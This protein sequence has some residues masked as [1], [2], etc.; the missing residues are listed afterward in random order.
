VSRVWDALRKSD[1]PPGPVE[2]R[3]PI[4]IGGFDLEQIPV[5]KIQIRSGHCLFAHTDPR[6]PAADRLRFLRMRLN[7]VWNPENL[8][9]ILITSPLPHDGKST[10]TINLAVTL[11]EQGKRPVLVIEGDLQRP[12]LSRELGLDDLA[13]VAECLESGANPCSLVRRIE[14]IGCYVL[15]AGKPLSNPSELLQR[16]VLPTMMEQLSRYF[17]WILIDSP[18]VAPLTDTLSWKQ[19]ADATLLLARAGSTPTRAVDEALDLLGRKH[20]LGIILNGVEGLDDLYKKYYR[21]YSSPTPH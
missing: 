12:A 10:I 19:R 5:E 17:D 8:K 13:G 21:A 11:A 2:S 7:Q 1:Y 14:P 15:P 20:V 18:P 6:G 4:I 16:G 3:E 9:R